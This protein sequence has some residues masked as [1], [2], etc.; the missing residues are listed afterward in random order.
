MSGFIET[1]TISLSEYENLKKLMNIMENHEDYVFVKDTW[2][3]TYYVPK[4]MGFL[5]ERVEYLASLNQELK[6][7]NSKLNGMLHK[8]GK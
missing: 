4:S 7:E 1:V 3:G 5:V 6:M 8:K 2:P